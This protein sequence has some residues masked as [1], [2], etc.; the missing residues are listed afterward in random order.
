MRR[1]GLD[2]ST[3][4][5][6]PA[7]DR[8]RMVARKPAPR[9]WQDRGQPPSSKG[10]SARAPQASGRHGLSPMV[11]RAR[12]ALGAASDPVD[13]RLCP[14]CAERANRHARVTA[15]EHRD[16]SRFEAMVQG[17]LSHCPWPARA[18]GSQR[19]QTG[20]ASHAA[21]MKNRA[22]GGPPAAGKACEW[23]GK[24]SDSG[25]PPAGVPKRAFRDSGTHALH[26][27][28]TQVAAKPGPGRP[29]AGCTRIP[30]AMLLTSSCASG[31]EIVRPRTTARYVLA[32][33]LHPATRGPNHAHRKASG[34]I[35]RVVARAS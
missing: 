34:V 23:V 7:S 27:P 26:K 19:R 8:A 9:G 29:P 10:L 28:S 20:R 31:T 12:P 5:S 22:A 33:V 35:S 4:R 1:P 13:A 24:T 11:A 6:A 32:C 17:A 14:P 16:P 2:L 15:R 30:N 3:R 25:R 21:P 18:A